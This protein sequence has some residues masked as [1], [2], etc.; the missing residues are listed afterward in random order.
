MQPVS[1][2]SS[3]CITRFCLYMVVYYQSLWV[4]LL[5]TSSDQFLLQEELP[6][7]SL[8][9][10]R[11]NRCFTITEKQWVSSYTTPLNLDNPMLPWSLPWHI[12]KCLATSSKRKS[13]V[14]TPKLELFAIQTFNCERGPWHFQTTLFIFALYCLECC[15]DPQSLPRTQSQIKRRF[16][17]L[18][19]RCAPGFCGNE[20]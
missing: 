11:Q 12:T 2:W 5:G 7:M 3:D 15:S 9:R 10:L 4:T 18:S 14:I 8:Y 17:S 1:W 20:I 16:Q 13:F 19:L 6:T